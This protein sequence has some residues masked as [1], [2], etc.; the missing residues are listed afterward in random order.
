MLIGGT[1]PLEFG[2]G[3]YVFLKVSPTKEITRFNMIGKLSPSYFG[4]Y[5]ITQ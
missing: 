2:V 4:P 3:D 5:P 1:S